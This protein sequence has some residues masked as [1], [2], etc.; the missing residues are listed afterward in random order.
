MIMARLDTMVGIHEELLKLSGEVDKAK[1]FFRKPSSPTR[2]LPSAMSGRVVVDR[3]RAMNALL[4]KAIHTAKAIRHLCDGRFSGDAYALGR[5]LL[6]NAV[7]MAWVIRGP[8]TIRLDTF[9]L[10]DT[11]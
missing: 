2:K 11:P 6:E 1:A 7:I 3:D 9:C 8:A 5:V 4:A 10:P